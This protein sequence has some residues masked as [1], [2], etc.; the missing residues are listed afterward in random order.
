MH[1]GGK[2]SSF[3]PICGSLRDN[4]PPKQA[5]AKQP[6]KNPGKGTAK[7]PPPKPGKGKGPPPQGAN[8][9]AAAA[10]AAAAANA[11]GAAGSLRRWFSLSPAA[12]CC[13]RSGA[14]SGSGECRRHHQQGFPGD[15]CGC[16]FQ[17]KVQERDPCFSTT[18]K[19][20]LRIN[21]D[22]HAN[23]DSCP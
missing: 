3:L 19:I 23:R 18:A 8:A 22:I 7:A 20:C 5:P 4:M 21:S 2:P 6:A 13:D 1:V 12:G 16:G 10:L 9:H 17:A 11:V 15:A 14:G